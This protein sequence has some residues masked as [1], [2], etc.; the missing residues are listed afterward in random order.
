MPHSRPF[1]SYA[2]RLIPLT[3]INEKL[4]DYPME[5]T[6]RIDASRQPEI[7]LDAYDKKILSYLADDGRRSYKEIAKKI[8][9]SPDAV[10]Y[11]VERLRN[12][13]VIRRFIPDVSFR[14]FGLYK[15]SLFIEL[16]ELPQEKEDEFLAYLIRKEHVLSVI[17][18]TDR[19]DLEVTIIATDAT[20]YD[21]VATRIMNDYPDIIEDAE[22]FQQIMSYKSVFL[23]DGYGDLPVKRIPQKKTVRPKIDRKDCVIL[24]ELDKDARDSSITIA[25]K[26]GTSVDTVLYRMRRCEEQKT[27]NR[28]TAL[29]NLSQL[30]F[31]WYTFLVNLKC[32]PK[33]KESKLKEFVRGNPNILRCVRGLGQWD[34][35]FYIVAEGQPAFHKVV[36]SIRTEFRDIIKDYDTLLAFQEYSF[37]EYSPALARYVG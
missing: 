6:G 29:I 13:N 9:L 28:Y 14:Q 10:S 25:K 17:K 20:E 8:R 36:S 15:Y 12:G 37:R 27:I 26:V 4:P 30:G 24:A 2:S 32:M 1:L 16:K 21:T 18:Y 11:R 19:F 5:P 33:D 3:F 35:I 31:S 7:K 23:P 22:T 34:L